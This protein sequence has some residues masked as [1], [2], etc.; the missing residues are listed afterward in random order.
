MPQQITLVSNFVLAVPHRSS[1]LPSHLSPELRSAGPAAEA[2]IAQLQNDVADAKDNLLLTKVTQ[3]HLAKSSWADEIVYNVGD[4]VM[5][6]TF[7]RRREYKRRGEKRVAKFFPWWDGPYTIIKANVESSSY[8][9]DNDNGYP[10]YSSELKPYHANDTDLLPGREHPKP[11]PVMTDDGLME[12]EIDRII[13]SRPW[14]CGYRY[15]IQ[16]V[17]YGPEDDEWLPGRMLEDCEA[18]NKWIERG[19]DR[20]DGPALPS[21]FS[22]VFQFFPGFLM[23]S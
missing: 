7:H 20:L 18:L 4:K 21:S 1:H 14:R 15:L 17:G 12:H 9:L 10:Y 8:S 23:H 11:G 2:M 5:L 3:A 16:W 19:G 22:R 6:S 13:D